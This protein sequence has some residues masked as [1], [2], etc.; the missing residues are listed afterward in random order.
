MH[1][2]E[3]H[4]VPWMKRWKVGCGCMGE[5][6]AESLHASFNNAEEAYNNMVDRLERL[7]VVLQNHHLKLLP[8]IKSLEPPPLK[9]R[10]K[11][12]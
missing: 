7:R 3:D 9:K 10:T 8:S 4:V 1:M 6:G 12:D 5:Q 2:L 11:K